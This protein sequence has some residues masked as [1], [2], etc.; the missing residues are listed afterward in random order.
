MIDAVCH[1][2]QDGAVSGQP[3]ER[4]RRYPGELRLTTGDEPPLVFREPAESGKGRG[5]NHICILYR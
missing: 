1:P 3:S 4:G 2:L 5:P